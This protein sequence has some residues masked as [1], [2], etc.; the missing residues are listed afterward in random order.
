MGEVILRG[1]AAVLLTI[2]GGLALIVILGL[3]IKL[4]SYVS[5]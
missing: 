3:I 1:L 4:A 5:T 2:I